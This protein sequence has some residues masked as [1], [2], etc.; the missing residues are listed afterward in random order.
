MIELD[1]HVIFTGSERDRPIIDDIIKK[2]VSRP[3]NFAGK[4]DLKELAC[5]YD[6][7][8][9]LVTTDHRPHAHGRRH[10]MPRG[11]AFRADFTP[12]GP[13]PTALDT[14]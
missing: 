3:S 10:G 6:H 4:T 8:R 2:M 9:T 12:Q 14:G 1:C 11:C 5:L 13:A 7:C